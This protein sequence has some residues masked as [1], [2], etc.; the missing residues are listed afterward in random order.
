M[1]INLQKTRDWRSQ[2]IMLS[3]GSWET[4]IELLSNEFASWRISSVTG[5]LYLDPDG[6]EQ[7]TGVRV[8]PDCVISLNKKIGGSRYK[9]GHGEEHISGSVPLSLTYTGSSSFGGRTY[10][11]DFYLWF[12][13]N[14]EC[15]DEDLTILRKLLST[16]SEKYQELL[17]LAISKRSD[18]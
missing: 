17:E 15:R 12:S 3:G 8:P 4:M 1:R 18:K 14:H 6:L 7:N 10:K 16:Q 13:G 11:C 9:D 2:S 5:D